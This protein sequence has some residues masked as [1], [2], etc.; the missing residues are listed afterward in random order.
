MSIG[1]KS[2]LFGYHQFLLH[3]LLVFIAWWKLYGF[4]WDPRL[5][6]A[7]LVHDWGYWG[8]PNMDGPEGETHPELGAYIM[9]RLFDGRYR[10]HW[11]HFVLFHSRFYSFRYNQPPS[12]LCHADKYV[13]AITPSWIQAAL[14]IMTGEH[15]EYMLG[16]NGRTAAGKDDT[17]FQ[18]IDRMRAVCREHVEKN[19]LR[20]VAP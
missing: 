13:I 12:R 7:F 16:Q 10:Y 2:L 19:V 3:P 17:L 1:T 5:W 14:F 4:P 11:K 20:K 8:K 15:E 9:W 18:W 6:I